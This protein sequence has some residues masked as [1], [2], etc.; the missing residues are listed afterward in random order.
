MIVFWYIYWLNPDFRVTVIALLQWARSESIYE[1]R[2]IMSMA[3]IL[4]K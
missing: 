4:Y 2:D 3:N 1:R